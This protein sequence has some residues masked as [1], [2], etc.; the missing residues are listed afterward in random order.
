[1]MQRILAVF[2]T[3]LLASIPFGWT[4][5][6]ISDQVEPT[7]RRQP[8]FSRPDK[9]PISLEAPVAAKAGKT[10]P[11]SWPTFAGGPTRNMVNLVD[12]NVPVTFSIE[13][14]KVKNVK[15]TTRLGSVSYSGPIVADGKIFVGTN[16]ARP[17]DLKL[18]DPNKAV[19]MAFNEAD[20][21]FLWQ[22]VHEMSEASSWKNFG[23]ISTPTVE[24][25]RIY[26]T[27]PGCIVVC[28]DTDGKVQWQYDMM[29][30]LKVFPHHCAGSSPLVVDDLLMVVTGN[31]VDEN[32]HKLVSPKAPSFVAFNK[33][34]GKLVWQSSLPGADIIEGQ[35]S[36]PSL[37]VVNGKKQVIFP[38]GDC[39]LYALE[40]ETGSL[41]W[42]C[43]C[44]PTRNKKG[45]GDRKIDNYIVASPVVVGDRL[46]VGLGPMPEHDHRGDVSYFLCLDIT[47]KGNVSLKN[48]DAKDA[49]NK[50]SAL[51]WSFGGPI[52]PAP[53]LKDRQVNLGVICA[54]ASVHDGLVYLAEEAGYL[55]CL[56]AKTGIRYWVH[57]FKETT[58]SSALYVDGKV[59]VFTQGGE[60]YAFV[61]GKE[62]KWYQDGKVYVPNGTKQDDKSSASVDD[63]PV[64]STPVVA[65]GV[66]Y[67][68]AKSTLYAIA[69]GK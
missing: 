20:G 43:D 36:N 8:S 49:A 32:T 35:W 21:K 48:Y 66:L 6:P 38:G 50:D 16:N 47:K 59:Y 17:R 58:W 10:E 3:V 9:E 30:E 55:H 61:A 13:P 5:S 12:K 25:K 63:N 62:R 33:K 4:Q 45:G 23:L 19:L 26:Y 1:M 14:G 53:P 54:T 15:W 46:Y 7:C 52:V 65:N 27:T 28:A 41:I 31:G 40:P 69:N 18:K 57:D 42:K 44:N 29:K 24:G 34:T 22:L 64:N 11:S 51:V 2:A 56:D 67:I 37:A 60:V 39:V 68:S